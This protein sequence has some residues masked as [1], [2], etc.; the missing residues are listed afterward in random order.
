MY[1]LFSLF[2]L[3]PLYKK[4]ISKLLH[5]CKIT[6]NNTPVWQNKKIACV[7]V[8]NCSFFFFF[9]SIF[10]WTS[11]ILFGNIHT[12][13]NKKYMLAQYTALFLFFWPS[14]KK[15]IKNIFVKS[16]YFKVNKSFSIFPLLLFVKTFVVRGGSI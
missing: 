13:Q 16:G 6:K 4:Y 2:R 11:M 1:S 3:S 15:F 10:F 14:N 5:K 8:S 7:C 9:F 12:S